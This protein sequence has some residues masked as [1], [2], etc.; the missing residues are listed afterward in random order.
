M[1]SLVMSARRPYMEIPA[2]QSSF[3]GSQSNTTERLSRHTTETEPETQR[4]EWR[5]S[6][7]LLG[8]REKEGRKKEVSKKVVS[9][10]RS[11][12]ERGRFERERSLRERGRFER[13]RE[14]GRFE[15]G[16]FERET[17]RFEREKGCFERERSLREVVSRGRFERSFRERGRSRERERERSR[18]FRERERE[19]SFRERER[20][21]ERERARARVSRSRFERV[22]FLASARGRERDYWQ[23]FSRER[24]ARFQISDL[25]HIPVSQAMRA[26][27]PS[28]TG[29]NG[30]ILKAFTYSFFALVVLPICQYGASE[31][32]N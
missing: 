14:R 30:L 32:Q 31:C 29:S 16:R 17:G 5:E 1:L 4:I 27:C 23:V 22:D 24:F 3:W 2:R 26:R 7:G 15:R 12:R 6:E 21:R 8:E 10:Q 9:R 13:E 19:R 20:E 18:S 25:R 11:F 28:P